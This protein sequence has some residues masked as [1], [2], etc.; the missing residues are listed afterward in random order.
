M[1]RK[2]LPTT[3]TARRAAPIERRHCAVHARSIVGVCDSWWATDQGYDLPRMLLLMNHFIL[4]DVV[5]H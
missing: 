4:A 3:W 5:C 1:N 2:V